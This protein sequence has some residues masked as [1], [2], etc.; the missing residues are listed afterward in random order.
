MMI[1]LEGFI[2]EYQ[3]KPYKELLPVK[4]IPIQDILRFEE[5]KID[6]EE[7]MMRPSPEVVYQCNLKYLSMLCE[8]IAEKYNQEFVLQEEDEEDD[9]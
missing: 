6:P 1:S 5:R 2:S 9:V 7:E 4:D 3:D 8:L